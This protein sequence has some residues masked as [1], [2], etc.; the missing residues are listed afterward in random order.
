M[1]YLVAPDLTGAADDAR[2]FMELLR[3]ELELAATCPLDNDEAVYDIAPASGDGVI[4]FNP[5][6]RAGVSPAV[7]TLLDQALAVGAVVLPVAL[8]EQTRQPPAPVEEMQSF[9]VTEHCA[10]RQLPPGAY[11][12]IAQEFARRALARVQPT[13]TKDGLR[14]FLCHRRVDGEGLVRRLD[15]TLSARHGHVFRDLIDIQTGDLAQ[16]VIDRE[17]QRA[18]VIVFFDTERSGESEWVAKELSTALGRHVP[19]VWVRLPGADDS[20]RAPLQVRPSGVPHIKLESSEVPPGVLNDVVDQILHEA[21]TLAQTHVRTAKFQFSQIR[22]RA[23]KAGKQVTVL[24]ARQMI[25]EISDPLPSSSYPARPAV[26]VVQL[27]GRHPTDEDCARL[28]RWLDEEGYG[29]HQRT[30][31]AFDA[32]VLLDPMPSNTE[33]FGDW[34]VVENAGRYLEQLP[35]PASELASTRPRPLLLLGAFPESAESHEPVKEAVYAFSLGWLR[36]GGIVVLGGHPT[37]TPLVTES[38]RVLLGSG[39][40]ERVR[41]YQ[42]RYFVTD[43]TIEALSATATVIDTPRRDD[44]TASM[45]LMREEMVSAYPDAVAVAIGGRTDEGGQHVPGIDEEIE[46]AR[47]AGVPVCLVGAPG[48]RAAELAAEEAG[49]GWRYLGNGLGPA[50]ELLATDEDYES[51][52][53]TV[54]E[55]LGRD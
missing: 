48:G 34:G 30:C 33:I 9:D 40:R 3:P 51:L 37:F 25:Y 5:E 17:L 18:D 41:I 26:H 20:T 2:R 39:G 55:S 24:D 46:L 23:A 53:E 38:A 13:L 8:S 49:Q 45:T 27:F 1:L 47:R 22:Q 19:I 35:D 15:Q 28:A 7:A 16:E 11:R 44:R 31:R 21:F 32:A 29:P 6:P 52:V 50:N 42:S 4:F 36:R 43:A 14:L 10:L 54:W 12:V